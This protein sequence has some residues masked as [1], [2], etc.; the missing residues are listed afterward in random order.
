[1]VPLPRG[2]PWLGA[3]ARGELT[4]LRRPV[5]V[6]GGFGFFRAGVGGRGKWESSSKMIGQS[7]YAD[8]SASPRLAPGLARRPGRDEARPTRPRR[9]K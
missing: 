3:W 6:V 9:A 8:V 5:T 7:A 4:L 1:M 2:A